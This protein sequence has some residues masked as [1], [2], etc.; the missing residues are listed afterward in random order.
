MHFLVLLLIQ[1]ALSVLSALL[2]RPKGPKA[3]PVTTP[4]TDPSAPIPV[5]FG[6]GMLG[7]NVIAFL[8]YRSIPVA[9]ADGLYN[10]RASM[11][12]ALCLGQVGKLWDIISDTAVRFSDISDVTI[13]ASVSGT[14][15]T[16]FT[17]TYATVPAA[18]V[19]LPYDIFANEG[20][21]GSPV[22][23]PE[24][25]I[26][27]EINAP[28]L[29]GSR[30]SGGGVIG[31]V[32]F[33][34]G[35]RNQSQSNFWA[36]F[37][38]PAMPGV[39][40]EV[41]AAGIARISLYYQRDIETIRWAV[42]TTAA[43]DFAA[44]N[45]GTGISGAPWAF[46]YSTLTSGQTLYVGVLGY[47]SLGTPSPLGSFSITF[48]GSAISGSPLAIGTPGSTLGNVPRYPNLCYCVY[49]NTIMGQSPYPRPL[50]F[51]MERPVR[52]FAPGF[53]NSTNSVGDGNPISFL[54]E[55]M[56]DR[57]WGIGMSD[58]EL[59]TDGS[60]ADASHALCLTNISNVEIGEGFYLSYVFD[61]QSPGQAYVDE[62]L[63]TIDAVKFKD[64]MTGKLGIKLIRGDYDPT[65]LPVFNESNLLDCDYSEAKA[66][67]TINEV[68]VTFTDRSRVYGKNQVKAQNTAS[69]AAL[70]KVIP[71]TTEYK[72]VTNETLALRLAQRDLR[73]YSGLSKATLVMNREGFDLHEGMPFKLSW[74]RAGQVVVSNQ[75]MRVGKITRT[76]R[77]GSQ[78]T[79][80]CLQ[81]TFALQT[82]ASTAFGPSG[83][84][85]DNPSKSMPPSTPEVTLVQDK[86]ATTGYAALQVYDPDHR[87]TKVEFQH[88]S[89]N[90]TMTAL[91]TA[92]SP[93]K[94]Q[95]TLDPQYASEIKYV[96]TYA[97]PD[98][99]IDTI[100]G[101]A[102]F[103]V[104][105]RPDAPLLRYTISSTGV[106]A[107]TASVE[108]TVTSV[109]FADSTSAAPS[110]ATT[111]AASPVT[112]TSGLANYTPAASP[113]AA[114]AAD[115]VTAFAYDAAGN[116]SRKAVLTI[117]SNVATG[118]P[119]ALFGEF[120]DG[121]NTTSVVAGT[122]GQTSRVPFGLVFNRWEIEAYDTAG[123]AVACTA[124][125]D[126][127]AT[128]YSTDVLA[129]ITASEQLTLTSA[130]KNTAATL[131][132]WT[133][134]WAADT[135]FRAK[136]VSVSGSPAKIVIAVRGA[137]S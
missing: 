87:I 30:K 57:L 28:H 134:T 16:G 34:S 122:Y 86:D 77:N 89:G 25:D 5:L 114:G 108:S 113:L 97:L 43:P 9:D 127:L 6:R 106:L 119:C 75:I 111:R 11:V 32:H 85:W 19:T 72:G 62:I 1:V 69:I 84:T 81:D 125:V 112:P 44:V 135:L 41:S 92:T 42:S 82:V 100:T 98:G 115:Y 94:D 109:K 83:T 61:A 70:K 65:T 110:D 130:S 96:V 132:G 131:T 121:K 128:D 126:I 56:T 14:A 7:G 53:D 2:F 24:G 48:A 133:K 66:P 29:Y 3:S 63:R 67:E 36:T 78:L 71:T 4:T 88:K 129:T 21:D 27:L 50:S 76:G 49:E 17:T 136:L 22:T 123:A 13:V 39:S 117:G 73:A 93:Y 101:T 31:D 54:Y 12:V 105:Q 91:A 33:F 80:E 116:E 60:W 118:A 137:K 99:S 90:G 35:S 103:D 45:S 47:N 10:Y 59:D 40:Y 102:T 107:V 23:A 120:G 15:Q 8:N 38:L 26:E 79:V 20:K 52:S 124:V 51:D 74:S 104:Q 46:T 95:V 58:S 64:P 18:G 68:R 55:L 37:P